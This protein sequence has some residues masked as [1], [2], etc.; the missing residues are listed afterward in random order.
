MPDRGRRV[1]GADA[2]RLEPWGVPGVP[3]AFELV[4]KGGAVSAVV[5]HEGWVEAIYLGDSNG[6]PHPS[7]RD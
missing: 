4:A 6:F 2:S 1:Q 5:G 3:E 7:V